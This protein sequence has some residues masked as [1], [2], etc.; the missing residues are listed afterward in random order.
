MDITVSSEFEMVDVPG[1][2]P[3]D[4]PDQLLF[5]YTTK[6]ILRISGEYAKKIKA[7]TLDELPHELLILLIKNEVIT[8]R[9]EDEELSD[10]LLVHEHICKSQY[11]YSFLDKNL[12]Y[13]PLKDENEKVENVSDIKTSVLIDLCDQGIPKTVFEDMI[14]SNLIYLLNNPVKHKHLCL[15]LDLQH[16]TN[17]VVIFKL[18]LLIEQELQD[19]IYF[20][21]VNLKLCFLLQDECW[22]IWDNH[23]IESLK[24]LSWIDDQMISFVVKTTTYEPLAAEENKFI[25]FA[26]QHKILHSFMEGIYAMVWDSKIVNHNNEADRYLYTTAIMDS[27]E[28]HSYKP[29]FN[30]TSRI[31]YTAQNQRI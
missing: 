12:K 23:V 14:E 25:D 18:L 17:P 21:L 20:G 24:S 29:L 15:L 10:P 30:M 2:V 28:D 19:N 3:H 27:I 1:Y 9:F 6:E 26:Y 4:Y 13:W 22:K 8:I 11:V 5:S 16:V 7:G 31:I